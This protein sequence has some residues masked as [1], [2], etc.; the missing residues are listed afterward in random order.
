MLG[1]WSFV[2]GKPVVRGY[3]TSPLFREDCLEKIKHLQM[4][5][6]AD[7]KQMEKGKKELAATEE[8]LK[9]MKKE[10]GFND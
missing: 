3:D 7:L 10:M 2:P 4:E 1:G 8:R 9:R 5:V 6:D